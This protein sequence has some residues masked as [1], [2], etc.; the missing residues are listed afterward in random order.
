MKTG[1]TTRPGKAPPV[2]QLSDSSWILAGV[3]L[4]TVVII[5]FG[6]TFL[7]QI[8]RVPMTDFQK[9]FAQSRRGTV[10]RSLRRWRSP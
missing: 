8:V 2:L 4:I 1:E 3:V 9:T 6:G 7:L 10:V 5:A